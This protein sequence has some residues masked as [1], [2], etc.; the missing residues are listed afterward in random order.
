[1]LFRSSLS[2][3]CRRATHLERSSTSSPGYD[4]RE[5]PG[6]SSKSTLAFAIPQRPTPFTRFATRLLAGIDQRTAPCIA[7]SSTRRC[8]CIPSIRRSGGG[9]SSRRSTTIRRMRWA[10]ARSSEESLWWTGV[11]SVR[12]GTSWIPENKSQCIS[13]TQYDGSAAMYEWRRWSRMRRSSSAGRVERL[14]EGERWQ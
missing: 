3:T 8:R 14:L 12:A 9:R 7:T 5:G 13:L 4:S 10:T 11:K 2:I 6:R 1:M